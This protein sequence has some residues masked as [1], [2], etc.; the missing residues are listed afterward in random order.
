MHTYNE[1]Q[2]S[3]GYFL[4]CSED[5][6][7]QSIGSATRL[8]SRHT[9]T[10]IQCGAQQSYFNTTHT[11][12]QSNVC[13]SLR[14][15]FASFFSGFQIIKQLFLSNRNTAHTYNCTQTDEWNAMVRALIVCPRQNTSH[16]C[17]SR[18][19]EQQLDWKRMI[20]CVS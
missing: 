13:Y 8:Y 6:Y 11:A 20:V 17:R 15:C 16:Q 5:K 10:H 3:F 2:A 4:T 1:S 12:Q 19:P 9:H 14:F 18:I 7:A